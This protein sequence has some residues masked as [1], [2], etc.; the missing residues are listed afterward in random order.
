[1]A[2]TKLQKF[3]AYLD[4]Y[5]YEY[6]AKFGTGIH[7]NIEL[8]FLVNSTPDSLIINCRSSEPNVQLND[9][10]YNGALLRKC[11]GVEPQDELGFNKTYQTIYTYEDAFTSTIV[12]LNPPLIDS[13]NSSTVPPQPT[14]PTS[15]V[16]KI[17]DAMQ[18]PLFLFRNPVENNEAVTKIYVDTENN[19]LKTRLSF[20]ESS[21]RALNDTIELLVPDATKFDEVKNRIT[22]LEQTSAAF[23]TVL[24]DYSNTVQ[25]LDF[26]LDQ[27]DIRLSRLES[28]NT[29]VQQLQ[30]ELTELA[31]RV[32]SID[33]RP[34]PVASK[35]QIGAIQVGEGLTIDNGILRLQDRVIVGHAI[36]P[37]D[38]PTFLDFNGLTLILLGSGATYVKVKVVAFNAELDQSASFLLEGLVHNGNQLSLVGSWLMTLLAGPP[39]IGSDILVAAHLDSVNKG[40]SV[41]C[42][43]RQQTQW[44]AQ[45]ELV[46]NA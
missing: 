1:M 30:H 22:S 28:S 16:R 6:R 19:K 43:W 33:T 32:A 40:L 24:N 25:T 35:D 4:S 38:D 11:V 44:T 46:A 20:T 17:G 12:S 29:L 9:F 3:L 23:G 8:R 45:I 37:S 21:I 36:S 42:R 39:G 27:A 7:D 34:L 2:A 41:S 13:P 15:Y 5:I 10:W 18:G 26:E 14:L 31:S